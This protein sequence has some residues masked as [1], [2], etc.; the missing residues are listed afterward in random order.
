MKLSTNFTL[1]EMCKSQTAERL[2]I[3]NTPTSEHIVNMKLVCENI[4]EPVRE[5]YARP[6]APSSGYR[7]VNLCEAIGS[8]SKSQHALGQ[9][10]DFEVMGVDNYELAMWISENLSF[11]QLILECYKGGNTGWVHC[12]YRSKDE[13]RHQCLTYDGSKYR[14]GLIL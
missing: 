9:A 10:V 4:L 2:G 1:S 6:I 11:D 13:N 3:D 8:N 7:S 14:Q 12:S 5:N